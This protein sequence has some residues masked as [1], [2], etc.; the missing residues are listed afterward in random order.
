[1]TPMTPMTNQHLMTNPHDLSLSCHVSCTGG[2][3]VLPNPAAKVVNGAAGIYNHL[4]GAKCITE[5][6]S[7]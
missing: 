2:K 3:K 6:C 5:C 1:M 4:T 7:E